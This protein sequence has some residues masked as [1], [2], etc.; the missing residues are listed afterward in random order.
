VQLLSRVRADGPEK[1]RGQQPN[2]TVPGIL[3]PGQEHHEN[4]FQVPEPGGGGQRDVGQR[5]GLPL[6]VQHAVLVRREAKEDQV[7]KAAGRRQVRAGW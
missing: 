7:G 2:A 3:R 5:H 6:R 1:V 4:G